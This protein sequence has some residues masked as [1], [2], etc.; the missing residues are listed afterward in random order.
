M[1]S[2]NLGD[3]SSTEPYVTADAPFPNFFPHMV[4]DCYCSCVISQNS[5]VGVVICLAKGL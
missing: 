3:V 5:K 1:K 2:V 4:R